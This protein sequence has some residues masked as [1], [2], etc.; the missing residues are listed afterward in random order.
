MS[1]T[2]RIR[3][4]VAEHSSKPW[5]Q[6]PALFAG[7]GADDRKRLQLWPPLSADGRLR[8]GKHRFEEA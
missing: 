6:K 4:C 2:V 5:Q 3:R 1:P 8:L 7:M